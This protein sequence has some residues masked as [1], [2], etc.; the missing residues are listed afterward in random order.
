MLTDLKGLIEFINDYLPKDVKY[1][2]VIDRKRQI[3]C[4]SVEYEEK[5]MNISI[6]LPTGKGYGTHSYRFNYGFVWNNYYYKC[7]R[8]LYDAD[9]EAQIVRKFIDAVVIYCREKQINPPQKISVLVEQ[10]LD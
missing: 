8:R 7:N 2:R 6:R 10:E 3:E 9:T 5:V 1:F 4:F